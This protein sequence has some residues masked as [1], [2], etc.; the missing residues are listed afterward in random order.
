M[1]EES[2]RRLDAG[3]MLFSGG[4]DA[5]V[6]LHRICDAT[7]DSIARQPER[8]SGKMRIPRRRLRLRMAQQ[9]TDDRQRLTTS[10][11]D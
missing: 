2:I 8:I 11:C 6:Y 5:G 10:R 1:A 4:D 9:R 3:K 7:A